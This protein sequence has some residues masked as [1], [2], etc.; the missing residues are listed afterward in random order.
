MDFELKVQAPKNA[1]VVWN[2][3][4]LKANLETALADFSSRVYTEETIAE[5][6]SDR[7]KLNKLKVAIN[8]ERINREREYMQ[9]FAEFKAQAKELCDLIDEASIG[10]SEQLDAF[11]QKRIDEKDKAIETLF[12]DIASNYDFP[13]ITLEKI[14]NEK[15]YNKG[16][17]DKAIAKEITEFFEKAVKDLE[18]IKRVPYAFEAEQVYKGSLDLNK[19]L[20]QGELMSR[21][22]GQKKASEAETIKDTAST[23]EIF[24]I[25][26]KCKITTAQAKALK[27]FCNENGIILER[28]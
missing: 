2:Y 1:P 27:A 16:V 20:E 13:F 26:F 28:I 7:A 6:K 14:F 23:Y 18:V 24:E 25:A 8:T 9:P 11:E 17:S 21:I 4:E 12:A 5:A 15:W 10:I 22:A 3:D 19:A